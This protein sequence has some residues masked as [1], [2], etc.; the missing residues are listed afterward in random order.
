MQPALAASVGQVSLHPSVQLRMWCLHWAAERGYVAAEP[1]G[2]SSGL[3]SIAYVEGFDLRPWE[4]G[5][6]K[7]GSQYANGIIP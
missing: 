1:A 5:C 3:A 4:A 7:D 2:M 6:W